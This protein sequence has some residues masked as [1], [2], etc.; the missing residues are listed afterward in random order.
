MTDDP[1]KQALAELGDVVRCQCHPA[2]KD[3][4]L[5][6][7]Q[8]QCDS[9]DALKVVTDRM[10]ALEAERDS[11]YEEAMH[12]IEL[13][14]KALKGQDDAWNDAIK[15]AAKAAGDAAVTVM[16]RHNPDANVLKR[17]VTRQSVAVPVLA[18]LKP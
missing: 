18:L 14:G 11:F 7:P 17:Q 4:G 15:A 8:C 16:L 6:D 13:W 2:F 1:V 12:H 9:A 3:R 5:K 10:E